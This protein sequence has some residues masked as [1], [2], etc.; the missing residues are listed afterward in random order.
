[1]PIAWE[2]LKEWTVKTSAGSTN[3]ALGIE[4]EAGKGLPKV[5]VKM[6]FFFFM[7]ALIFNRP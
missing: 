2:G 7:E 6:V 3:F 5:V 1:M 4:P